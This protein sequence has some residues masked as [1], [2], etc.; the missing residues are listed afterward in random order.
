MAWKLLRMLWTGDCSRHLTLSALHCSMISAYSCVS[1]HPPLD[2][3]SWNFILGTSCK[4]GKKILVSLKLDKS[5]G[6]FT[7]SYKYI[8]IVTAIS[9]AL[10][11]TNYRGSPLLHFHGKNQQVYIVD[12]TMWHNIQREPVAF[13]WKCFLGIHI[14]DSSSGY[15]N[16]T[17]CYF[18]RTL[19]VLLTCDICKILQGYYKIYL[20]SVRF[21]NILL[22]FMTLQLAEWIY[23]LSLSMV[24]CVKEG[25]TGSDI[26]IVSVEIL[27]IILMWYD[28]W[29]LQ[30]RP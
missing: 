20:I 7:W 14:V 29:V 25:R 26:A 3:L 19:S 9:Y 4:S 16:A 24:A 17:Q 1:A 2:R 12:R 11:L 28:A 21:T 22:E 6:H 13:P 8:W 30:L 5:I 18:M 23:T 15:T 27:T 10:F